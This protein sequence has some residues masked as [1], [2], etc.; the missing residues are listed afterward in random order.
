VASLD[1]SQLL[2]RSNLVTSVDAGFTASIS[3]TRLGSMRGGVDLQLLPSRVNQAQLGP[4][5]ISL[6]LDRG[7]L[8]G[9]VRLESRDGQLTTGLAGE[10][11]GDVRRLVAD[12]TLRIERLARWTGDTARNGRVEGKFAI[13]VKADAA[14]LLG[15]GGNITAIGGVGRVRVHSLHAVFQPITGTVVLDTLMVRS[16]VLRLDGGGRLPLRGTAAAD[17]LRIAGRTDDVHAL[18]QLAGIDS[19]SLDS[20]RIALTLAGP[21]ERRRLTGKLYA[22]RLL[23]SSTL[24]EQLEANATATA[25]S[26]GLGDISGR[27]RLRG[28]A[29]GSVVLP[30]AQ[31]AG[32][33]DSLVALDASGNLG[34]GV[35]FS[36]ALQ[37]N[38]QGDS[39]AVL[40][41]RLQLVEGGRTW[42]LTQT[43]SVAFRPKRIEVHDFALVHAHRMIALEGILAL[44][45]TSNLILRLDSVELDAMKKAGLVPIVGVIDGSLRLTGPAGDP[46]VD[47]HVALALHDPVKRTLAGIESGLTWSRR[48]LQV[49]LA[50]ARGKGAGLTIRGTLPWGFTLAPPDS[51]AKM[52]VI[53]EPGDTLNLTMQA[54]SFDLS[55]LGSIVPSQIARN[56][57]GKLVMDARVR[58][59]PEAPLANGDI[60]LD[61]LGLELSTLHV[62]YEG[63]RLSGRLLGEVLRIDT[64]LLHTG[65]QEEL[66]A[67]GEVR[68]R[69]LT[70]P[71]LD[72]NG[73]LRDFVVSNS[74]TLQ[75]QGSGRVGLA[76]TLQTPV[77]TGTL[78]MGHTEIQPAG[79]T[80]VPVENVKLT[81]E[82][83]LQLARH[84]GP[85]V[86]GRIGSQGGFLDRFRLDLL[87]RLPEQVWFRRR[88]SPQLNV[89]V[90]GQVRL[91]Q[92]PH[93]KMLLF[94]AVEPLAGRSTL[95][96]YGRTFQLTGGEILL[97]G[98]PEQ[99]SINVTAEY[100]PPTQGGPDDNPV[101]ISVV[102][103]G[104][105][106]S[107]ALD[108]SSQPEM[109]RDDIISYIVTGRPSSDN[110]LVAQPGGPSQG[111][112]LA[113]SQLSEV[114]SSAVSRELG[115]DV[116]QIRQDGTRGLVLTAG[117]YVTPHFYLSLQQPLQLG[118][119][120][121]QDP[122]TN[123]GPAFELQYRMQ[124]WLRLTMQGGSIPA[125]VLLR[126]RHAY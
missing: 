55:L 88:E 46:V 97:R 35:R 110:P 78:R 125:G 100:N 112:Q 59:T 90:A 98:P 40:L 117:R 30:E 70:N 68:L 31:L 126:G 111:E 73:V 114:V 47:G 95:D 1:L 25:Y 61:Q 79:A 76:G 102:A 71:H 27:L 119:Q 22:Y 105:P 41:K 115:L 13:E 58:G 54:D 37:G 94:G 84:F 8:K 12:G 45:D 109:S 48:G 52:A 39:M 38:R 72:L 107:I 19:L 104:R 20:S 42:G 15:I 2:G 62:R 106:D 63:G 69:P 89:E 65:K 3:G 17:T 93:G 32:R 67:R 66:R 43:A 34:H 108:F 116:F 26:A 113:L 85:R 124:P 83:Q 74:A 87:L 23:Y 9:K 24:A 60:R 49:D 6:S 123:L 92:E 53:R 51:S 99:A 121:N 75:A 28:L 120:A 29:T 14:G 10:L 96:V 122:G 16:N 57:G 118:G 33:Y 77:V 101:V 103:R 64:L 18:A 11:T 5:N 50:A 91:R 81:P 4:G 44:R 7:E 86:L 36:L 82:D 56:L 80:G 21:P